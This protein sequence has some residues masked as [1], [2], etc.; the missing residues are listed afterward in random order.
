MITA[1]ILRTQLN[2]DLVSGVFTWKMAKQGVKIGSVAGTVFAGKGNYKRWR[3]VINTKGYLAHRL[4]WLYV[5]GVWPKDQIDHIDGDALN[6]RID[7]LREA[8][9]SE[10]S[11]NRNKQNNNKSGFMGVHW[12]KR[13]DK[14]H[15]QIKHQGVRHHL[16][17]FDTPEEA[18][19]AYLK[20]KAEL[21]TFQPT[22]RAIVHVDGF[23]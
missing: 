20:A 1:D 19:A 17:Y 21:H 4:A 22:P 2:Y 11:Q 9:H 16:G 14:W 12:N 5:Y 8:A 10:N 6:N 13:A 7:N 23:V 15:A 18:H 3:I